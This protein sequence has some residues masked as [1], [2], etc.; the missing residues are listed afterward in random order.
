LI[1]P[2]T[3]LPGFSIKMR[4]HGGILAPA[5]LIPLLL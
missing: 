3:R 4:M 5:G 2:V 1:S